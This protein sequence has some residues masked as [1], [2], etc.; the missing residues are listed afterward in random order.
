LFN[1]PF[2]CSSSKFVAIGYDQTVTV[3]NQCGA[4]VNTLTIEKPCNAIATN[5]DDDETIGK[6]QPTERH[7]LDAGAL[8]PSSDL[9]LITDTHKQLMVWRTTDWTIV[10]VSRVER[11]LN[12]IV[13]DAQERNVLMA[14]RNGDVLTMPIA[15]DEGQ[16]TDP[17]KP[18]LL[19]GHI[20]ML[21][22]VTLCPSEQFIITCDRDDKIRVS[23]YPNAYNVHGYCLGHSEYVANVIVMGDR[24]GH[25]SRLLSG[26]GDGT[27]RMWNYGANDGPVQVAVRD[28]KADVGVN[29]KDNAYIRALLRIDSDRIAVLFYGKQSVL[30]YRISEHGIELDGKLD[31]NGEP[32]QMMMVNGNLL[33]ITANEQQ[34]VSAFGMMGLTP[35]L[36]DNVCQ[37]INSNENFVKQLTALCNEEQI[38]P[39]LKIPYDTVSDYEK[40]K[41]DRETQLAEKKRAKIENS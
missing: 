11:R 35:V 25:N 14:D 23:H 36:N 10:T 38:K 32:F 39:L 12:K 21:L 33:V 17:I 34:M 1:M 24:D 31:V 28:C 26:S 19:L 37:T 3:Y 6:T 41:H 30:V 7:E 20:A 4:L 16:S 5:G 15:I 13:F 8:S 2:I 40:R 27:L 22:D 29:A 9:L 18:H